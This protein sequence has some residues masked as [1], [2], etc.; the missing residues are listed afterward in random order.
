MMKVRSLPL[1]G[2]TIS[3]I[4]FS[5]REKVPEGRMRGPLPEV[6][7]PLDPLAPPVPSSGA[8]RHLLPMGEGKHYA[9][10]V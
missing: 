7:A 10:S 9:M 6:V 8:A 2:R 3:A 5:R 1:N 4:A